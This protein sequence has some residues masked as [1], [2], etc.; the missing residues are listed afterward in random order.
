MKTATG[1]TANVPRVLNPVDVID[2]TDTILD[3]SIIENG[4]TIFLPRGVEGYFGSVSKIYIPPCPHQ[5]LGH[6]IAL[7]DLSVKANNI[8]RIIEQVN[9]G[10]R[11]ISAVSL[12]VKRLQHLVCLKIGSKSGI[13][14]GSQVGT[15]VSF[16][17]RAVVIPS[18]ED[19][20][21]WIGLPRRAMNKLKIT[22]G[23]YVIAGRDPVI[24]DG[25]VEVLMA[26]ETENSAIEMHPL[27]FAQ[28]NADCDGDTI[29]VIK[30]P[31][32]DGCR[33]ECEARKLSFCAEN[34]GFTRNM[35]VDDNDPN[36]N[37]SDVETQVKIR[38]RTTGYSVSPED[39]VNSTDKLKQLE[40]F[41]GKELQDQGKEVALGLSEQSLI[42]YILQ[43]N[44]KNLKMKVYLGPVGAASN[45]LKLISR[46]NKQLSDSANY[47][48]H[49]VL[50]TLF[51]SK[52]GVGV[53][54]KELDVQ[55][56]LKILNLQGKYKSTLDKPVSHF[57]VLGRLA[58][59]GYDRAKCHPIVAEVYSCHAFREVVYDITDDEDK[60]KR[61]CS[62]IDTLRD[63]DSTS[64]YAKCILQQVSDIL[65]VSIKEV[66]M[67]LSKEK[68][69][70]GG[71]G[72]ILNDPVVKL[73][74]PFSFDDLKDNMVS[75]FAND[76]KPIPMS[77]ASWLLKEAIERHKEDS[78]V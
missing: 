64:D 10:D 29:W 65:E 53:D 70:L 13:L 67:R 60:R 1:E 43:G 62:L 52:H 11:K 57:K 31:H 24:W 61:C 40:K 32:G 21:S 66:S 35:L 6:L 63:P 12:A 4:G 48:S 68:S 74:S 23:D 14:Q 47:L 49:E 8:L 17:L 22:T 59:S 54:N 42:D 78:N 2:K 38:F 39:I 73:M 37:W 16:S 27:L 5:E 69:L 15:R 25:S 58:E 71:I 36:V 34:A 9:A 7:D 20:P 44:D 50:Q 51:D 41:S 28:M 3:D 46:G 72:T 45:K 19:H 75:S 55:E 18:A 76:R 30:V 56:V 33:S 77:L 26:R